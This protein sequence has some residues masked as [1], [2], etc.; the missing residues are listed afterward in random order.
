MNRVRK[1]SVTRAV[2]LIGAAI[3]LCFACFAAVFSKAN[4]A[5]ADVDGNFY[6]ESVK[7]DVDVRRDKTFLVTETMQVGFK[8]SGVN[9]GIIRDIQRVSKTTKFVNGKRVKGKNFIAK[10]TD[11]SVKI[12]G[13]DAK[14]TRSLYD[15][16]NFHS[17]KMQ[18]PEGYFAAGTNLFEL[19]YVYDMSDDRSRGFDDFTFDVLGYAMNTVRKFEATVAFPEGTDLSNVTLRTNHMLKFTPAEKRDETVEI[20]EN[21]IYMRA[22]PNDS[23]KGYTVQVILPKEYF[24]VKLTFLWYYAVFAAAT[25]A[26]VIAMI[27]LLLKNLPEKPLET[28]EFYPP[29]GVDLMHFAAIWCKKVKSKHAAALLLKWAG[30][31]FIKIESDGRSN[32]TLYPCGKRTNGKDANGKRYCETSAESNYYRVLFSGI[33]GAGKFST[34]Y[35]KKNADK[36]QMTRLYDA[37]KRLKEQGNVKY[38]GVPNDKIKPVF[39]VLSFIPTVLA[40]IYQSIA[41]GTFMPVFFLIFL[42]AGTVVSI[43]ALHIKQPVIYLMTVFDYAIIFSAFLATI[44]LP[45]YDY[46]KIIYLAPAIYALGNF[47]FPYLIFKRADEAQAL[48]GKMLGFKRFLLYAELPRIQLMFD[49]NPEY[50]ADVLPYCLIMGI[51]DIVKKR[52]SALEIKVPPYVAENIDTRKVASEMSYLSFK[53]TPHSSS[54]GG[55]SSSGGGGGHSGSSGGGGGGGGSR[56]C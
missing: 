10:L 27:V 29:E 30:A 39:P 53:G 32:L 41:A 25:A 24:D 43:A 20:G 55:G 56:G 18:R 9:T 7:V 21:A 11:V 54:G 14:V 22:Y 4:Y 26:A 44:A 38:V 15:N 12:N 46:A 16:G 6:F 8:A 23:N 36:F 33:G 49:E 19:S 47:L 1:S 50:F 13:G 2:L 5:H 51:S 28:V 48:Y 52:F 31:G 42:A 45:L 35:Y 3:C 17:I 40:I 37:T 34:K